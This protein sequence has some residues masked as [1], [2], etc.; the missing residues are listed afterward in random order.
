MR[1]RRSPALLSGLEMARRAFYLSCLFTAIYTTWILFFGVT[2]KTESAVS[3]ILTIFLLLLTMLLG[4]FIL[5]LPGF[6]KVLRKT[7]ITI[8]FAASSQLIAECIW[9]YEQTILGIDPFPS[10]ADYFYFFYYIFLFA[11]VLSL[12]F[13]PP[14]RQERTLL[15]MDIVIVMLVAILFMYYFVLAPLHPNFKSPW[16][17]DQVVVSIYPCLDLLILAALFSFLQRDVERVSREV[18]LF[19][20]ISMLLTLLA[21]SGWLFLGSYLSKYPQTLLDWLWTMAVLAMLLATYWQYSRPVQPVMTKPVQFRPLLRELMLYFITGAAFLLILAAAIGLKI[22]D[23][24]YYAVVFAGIAVGVLVMIRQYIILAENR[25]LY[26]EME[27]LATIDQLTGL[28]NRRSFDHAIEVESRRAERFEHPY[29]VLMMDV[30]GFKLYN[31][32]FGHLGG[33]VILKR[34]AALLLMNLRMTDFLARFG[35][36]E[37]VAILPETLYE[38]AQ[39]VASKIMD[40]A[41]NHFIQ[42]SI[43]L[44]VG[45]ATWKPGLSYLDVLDAADRDLYKTKQLLQR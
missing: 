34:M 45:V 22:S 33:D 10:I 29:S 5:R 11:A 14:E 43:G 6:P 12:P 1:E 3:S 38:S 23:M 19:L 8:I 32:R 39:K 41:K 18:I 35:G 42:E 2:P 27:R 44:S 21:D 24:R 20:S 7:W 4:R 28:N 36:D 37:F 31:D 13:T 30:D 15:V 25:R 40:E 17:L 26:H 16:T 9:F